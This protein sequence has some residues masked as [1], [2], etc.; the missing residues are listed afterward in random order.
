MELRLRIPSPL[1]RAAMMAALFALAAP[2]TA[3]AAPHAHAAKKKKAKAPLIT[4]VSPLDVAVGETLTIRGKNFIPGRLKNTVV[5]KRD[6]ARAVF[7]KADVGTKKLLAIKVP[8][9]L[10]EF[11]SLRAGD[12]IPTRFR[13]R[14]LAGRFAKR[15]TKDRLS[16]VVSAPRPPK[17]VVPT[18]S[19]PDGDCD[20]D[21]TKNRSD[22]DDDNDGLA[23]AVEL[24]LSLDPCVA[25]TDKD[26]LLDKWEFDCDRDGA[27]NRDEPDDDD[28]LLSDDNE[29]R[30]G[31]N[32]C[33]ADTDGD[34]VG[35]GY[36]YRSAVDLND[37]EFQQPN[38]LLAHPYKV[39][40]PNA[41]F[42]DSNTDYDG[43]SLT[44]AEEHDLWVYTYS[45]T[46]TDPRSLDALSYSDGEQYTRSQRI[47]GGAHDGRR[48]PTLS[49]TGYDKHQQFLDWASGA[50]YRSVMLA[51]HNTAWWHDETA[52]IS[53]G[54]FDMN[55]DGE[56]A[57]EREYFDILP[58][59]YLSDDERDEDAD[60]LVNYDES[61]GRLLPE[62][63]TSCYSSEKRFQIAYAG[64]SLV[65]A[66]TDG[67]GVRDG[68]DDQ[69]HDDVP[70]V[71]EMSR[72]DASGYD[73]REPGKLCTPRTTGLPALDPLN[74]HS[75]AYG[76]V[77]PFNPCLPKRWSRTCPS[78]VSSDTG[79][80]FDGSPNWYSLN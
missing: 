6:G 12:P 51:P 35:D 1:R 34:G 53:Y 36:E 9:S 27:L 24:S 7:A 47:V 16:P 45:V 32:P 78:K 55:R 64:T 39:D 71:M 59:G 46:Q 73:D 3:G 44:L 58:D 42:A 79:A 49:A 80:P 69:D 10:Q 63:W 70:N 43:D 74:N 60:G 56:T 4:S 67:D 61:H 17:A 14:V 30:I 37:D 20:G 22:G 57:G 28:D 52:L 77:N 15:F 21:G 66:D 40:Y 8:G 72:I 33:V 25:D 23:D 18:E 76:R 41:G 50:G 75:G 2:A 38:K 13:L 26:G 11:F 54:L 48:N 29:T 62:Y 31:T 19:L 68:A 5:F 65:D